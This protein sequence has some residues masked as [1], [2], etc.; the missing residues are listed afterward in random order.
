MNIAVVPEVPK[1]Q[2]RRLSGTYPE[3]AFHG[4]C[5]P[6]FL[7]GFSLYMRVRHAPRFTGGEN[8]HFLPVVWKFRATIQA[9]HIRSCVRRRLAATLSPLAGLGKADAFVPAT[10]Q[11]VKDLHRL[12]PR[13]PSILGADSALSATFGTP[14]LLFA[15]PDHQARYLRYLLISVFRPCIVSCISF[16]GLT[17]NVTFLL[18]RLLSIR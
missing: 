4:P 10:K 16:G 8:A 2:C 13:L 18:H 6:Q 17:K 11:S 15:S 5:S 3:F 1:R 9:D 12:L 7:A 14:G